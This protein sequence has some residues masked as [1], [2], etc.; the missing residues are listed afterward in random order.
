MQ[1]DVTSEYF[2]WLVD[3][4]CDG[5]YGKHI[6]YRRLLMYLHQTEF[7]YSILRDENRA[8]DGV[9]LRYR[10][11][12]SIERPELSEELDGPCSILE[13]MVAL[14]IRCEECIMDNPANGDRTGQWFWGMIVSLGLGSMYDNRFDKSFVDNVVDTFLNREYSPNGKGGLFTIKNCDYDLR[15]VEIWRQ[16]CW[17]IDSIMM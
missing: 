8:E 14:A 13:M 11:A 4:V 9:D 6:S 17:Y 1:F 16:L 10:F 3:K 7:Q 5:R 12:C 2:E 15:G